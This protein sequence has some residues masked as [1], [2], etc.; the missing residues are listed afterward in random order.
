MLLLSV[1]VFPFVFIF[2][3]KIIING[4]DSNKAN[5]LYRQIALVRWEV[6]WEFNNER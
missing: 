4:Y 6:R 3:Y 2:N 5:Y 1:Y